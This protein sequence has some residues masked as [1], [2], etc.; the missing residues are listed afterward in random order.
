MMDL[1]VM[2]RLHEARL[3]LGRALRVPAKDTLRAV[4][5][6]VKAVEARL[7]TLCEQ[8]PNLRRALEIEE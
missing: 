7:K 2:G 8:H 5:E 4:K 1:T 6:Q 3:L